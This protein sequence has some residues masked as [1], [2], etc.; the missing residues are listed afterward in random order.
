VIWLEGAKALDEGATVGVAP[1]FKGHLRSELLLSGRAN[2][3]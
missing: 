1:A 2:A 3:E